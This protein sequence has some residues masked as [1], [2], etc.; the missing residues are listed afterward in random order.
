MKCAFAFM[1]VVPKGGGATWQLVQSWEG[2]SPLRIHGS[3]SYQVGTNCSQGE[4]RPVTHP[5]HPPLTHPHTIDD[6]GG[7]W[8]LVGPLSSLSRGSKQSDNC[9]RT[10]N[11]WGAVV[12]EAK[13]WRNISLPSTYCPKCSYENWSCFN[14]GTFQPKL[15]LMLFWIFCHFQPFI[16]EGKFFHVNFHNI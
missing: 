9:Q 5:T 10:W 7:C 13:I 3:N 16:F 2:S 12:K 4:G 14:L 6:G 11:I 15:V 8:L 1:I